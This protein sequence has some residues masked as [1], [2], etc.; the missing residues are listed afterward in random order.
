MR[1]INI[2]IACEESQ[3][4]CK[5][6]REKG[7]NAYSCDLKECS[8][9]HPEWH[10]QMDVFEAI[11]LK[12]W[13]LM[14]AHPPCTFLAVSGNRWMNDKVHYPNRVK[15]REE[16]INFFLE[17]ASQD[18]PHIVIENPIGV[19]STIWKK[20]TQIIH[21]WQFGDSAEKTTCLWIKGLSP[22]EPTNIVNHGDF[23]ITKSGKKLPKWYSDAL[24]AKTPEERRTIRSKT[25]PGIAKA[26][27]NQ[28]GQELLKEIA[29]YE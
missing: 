10:L 9:G 12:K 26:M 6:F 21:P 19:M 13:D 14:I 23:I 7:F 8:G 1:P 18:I 22:L 27:A 17:L 4:I 28:W 20:P 3:A 15:D 11:K 16:A 29:K 25:F 2:L 5:A 24:K